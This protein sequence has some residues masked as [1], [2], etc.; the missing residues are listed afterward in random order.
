MKRMVQHKAVAAKDWEKHKARIRRW[1]FRL[2]MLAI[3]LALANGLLGIVIRSSSDGGPR[4]DRPTE[5]RHAPSSET[6]AA[7]TIVK[8]VLEE[9]HISS[10]RVRQREHVYF[11]SIPEEMRFIDFHFRLNEKLR[12]I[13]GQISR[14]ID[15]RKNN[16]YELTITVDDEQAAKFV[17]LRKAGLPA[18]VGKLAIIVDDFGYGYNDVVNQFICFPVP[19]TLAILPGLKESRRIAQE[20]QLAGREIL[21]HM[22]MEPLNEKFHD[23]GHYILASHDPGTIRLRIRQAFSLLPEASGLNNHQGSRVVIDRD[24]MTTVMEEIKRQNKIFID[25]YTN[26]R[27]VALSV[28]RSLNVPSAANQVFIDAKD[29]ETFIENQL[30]RLAHLAHK[31]GKVVGIAHVRKKTLEV[32]Q[33]TLPELRVRGIELVYISEI[34]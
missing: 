4:P 23:D 26:P 20:A 25:S 28:A 29:D 9:F 17:F 18:T 10:D 16:R 7:V 15:N 19:L 34:L 6:A 22:P 32:F 31:Q 13:D 11:V 27:S 14:T 30:A 3:V 8:A 1:Q 12:D 2:S 5:P 21:L 33:R 24:I